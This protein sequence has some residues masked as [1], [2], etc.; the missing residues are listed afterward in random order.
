MDETESLSRMRWECECHMV[1]SE[2][3]NKDAV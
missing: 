3:Q 2:A 1:Y